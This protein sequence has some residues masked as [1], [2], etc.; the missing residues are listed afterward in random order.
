M[1]RRTGV[2]LSYICMIFEVLSTLLLTPFII[3]TLGQAEYGVYKLAAAV[4]AY[5]MLLDLGIGSAV[6]RYVSKFKA[7]TDKVQERRFFGIAVIYYSVIAVITIIIGVILVCIFPAIFAKGLTSDEIVL[8]QKLLCVTMINSAVT[9]GTAVYTNIIIAYEKFGVSKGSSII[10]IVIRILL[11]YVLL[12]MGMGSLGLVL[13]NLVTTILCKGF[14]IC[15]VF[16]SLKLRPLFKGIEKAFIKEITMYSSLIFLQ[17]TATQLN[18]TVD[19]VLIGALVTSSS[20]IIAMYGIGI[21]I[22]QYFQS[23][24]SDFNRVLMPGIVKMIEYK[25]SHERLA[26]EMVRISRI[27][28]MILA[29]IW[30]CFLVNGKTFITLWAGKENQDAFY[31]AII[32][33]SA[34]IFILTEDVGTLIL[35]AMNQHREQAILKIVIVLINIILTVILIQW[36]PLIGATI[37]TFLSLVFGD[38]GVLN[39]ILWKKIKLNPFQY[40][41][42]LF[43][44]ILP[45]VIITIVSGNAIANVHLEGWV[46]F[47]LK[48]GSMIVIY[49]ILM[50]SFG[51]NLYEKK[52]LLSFVKK[53]Q[54]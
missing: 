2:I 54:L 20:V 18:A 33:M 41:R 27:A 51:I 31:V 38:I 36:R 26:E 42:K 37:G 48:V 19:Q 3:Q 15:Y 39:W 17:M 4:N 24:G 16:L 5:L 53:P 12:K 10:Q 29:L 44:G 22:V 9:L 13:V 47:V 8:G 23:I 25:A 49:G 45:C 14:F 43:K 21:Q 50:C 1:N 52:L 28:F 35:W 11:T 34:Y 40:Y 32:L 6:T 7:D 30:G 46:G